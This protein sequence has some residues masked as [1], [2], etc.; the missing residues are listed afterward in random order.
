MNLVN[1]SRLRIL[2]EFFNRPFNGFLAGSDGGEMPSLLSADVAWSP[3]ADIS[4]TEKEYLIKAQLPGVDKKA[5]NILFDRGTLT[6]EGER[7]I[8]KTSEDE[9]IRRTESFYGKYSRSFSLPDDIDE[10]AVTAE[11]KDGVLTI[12]LPKVTRST[13]EPQKIPVK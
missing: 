13:R 1:P 5:V 12:H 9:E 3:A 8:E 11:S 10:K 6:I 7:K 2:D 4:E